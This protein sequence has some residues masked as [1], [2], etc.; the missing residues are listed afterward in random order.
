MAL[1]VG[2]YLPQGV[3]GLLT[4]RGAAAQWAPWTRWLVRKP[5]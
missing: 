5:K 4:S 1:L 2:V 3:V